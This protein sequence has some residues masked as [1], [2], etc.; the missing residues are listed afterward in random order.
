MFLQVP[1]DNPFAGSLIVAAVLCGLAIGSIAAWMHRERIRQAS[2]LDMLLLSRMTLSLAELSRELHGRTVDRSSLLGIVRR[3]KNAIL[4]FGGTRVISR[5]LLSRRLHDSLIEEAVIHVA[6]VADQYDVNDAVIAGLVQGI[7]VRERLDVVMTTDGDFVLVPDLRARF[8]DT[9]QIHGRIN[10]ESEAQRLRVPPSELLR[11][12]EHWGWELILSEDG[13]LLSVGWLRDSLGRSIDRTG[14]LDVESEARRLQLSEDV[15]LA[16][17]ERFGWSMIRTDDGHLIPEHTVIDEMRSRL[18]TD[19]LIDIGCEAARLRIPEKMLGALIRRCNLP[20]ANAND[21]TVYSVAYLARALRDDLELTGL[22]RP[23]IEAANYGIQVPVIEK[24]L[25]ALPEV[26]R[27]RDGSYIFLPRLRVW[28]MDRILESGVI[29]LDRVRKEWGLEPVEMA[30]LLKRFEA[31]F[32]T[33]RSGDF[34]SLSW[35][36]RRLSSEVR[37]GRMIDA[38]SVA[39]EFDLEMGVAEAILSQVDADALLTKHGTLIPTRVLRDELS[40]ILAGVGILDPQ[41]EA[42]ERGL[43]PAEIS[44][45]IEGIA[46]EA[47]RTRTGRYILP[48]AIVR[49]MQSRLTANGIF[50]IREAARSLGLPSER[51]SGVVRSHAPSDAIVV[52]SADSIVTSEWAN[53]LRERAISQGYVRVTMTA[54]EMGL[55]RRTLMALLRELLGGRYDTDSDTFIVRD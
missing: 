10:I 46:H 34:L 5:P 55:K 35:V 27:T 43:D 31:S 24:I 8:A 50:D 23:D 7:V 32:V 14:Y 6:R 11:L 49:L 18:E 48:S 12:V 51:L 15:I 33:T 42:R 19:G 16:L 25:G 9:L 2:I 13:L 30:F 45:V 37:R 53:R 17:T 29:R 54:R 20:T 40:R 47:I 26:R 52:D 3:S 36:R 21:G 1:P 28:V 22:V 39:G 41:K 44:A 38:E 4:S